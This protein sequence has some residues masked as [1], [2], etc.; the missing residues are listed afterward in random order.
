MYIQQEAAQFLYSHQ[1][2]WCLSAIWHSTWTVDSNPNSC[3]KGRKMFL[4]TTSSLSQSALV[5]HNH[6]SAVGLSQDAC[7]PLGNGMRA[8]A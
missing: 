7:V 1:V 5:L 3:V 4:S 6:F 2:I 8:Y